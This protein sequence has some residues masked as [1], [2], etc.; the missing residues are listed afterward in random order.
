MILILFCLLLL[1]ANKVIFSLVR[2]DLRLK[3]KDFYFRFFL[4]VDRLILLIFGDDTP[5][6]VT[7]SEGN[8]FVVR[9]AIN[10]K[11]YNCVR[12]PIQVVKI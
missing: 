12:H 8:K 9:K 7:V 2:P 4:F 3:Y 11:L 10:Y 1:T 6:I 5:S